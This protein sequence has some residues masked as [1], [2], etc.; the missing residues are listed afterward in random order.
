MR[1][2]IVEDN[3]AVRSAIRRALTARGHEIVEAATA[4]EGRVAVT[5][6]LDAIVLDV[7][8]PDGSGFDVCRTLRETGV[9]TPILMLTAMGESEDRIAGLESG[10]DDYLAKPFEPRELLLRIRTILRR[11]VEPAPPSSAA[12]ATGGEVLFGPF[13]FDL[14][15]NILW[16]GTVPVRLT[17][18]EATLLRA[19]ALAPG[20]TFSREDLVDRNA[21][22]GGIRTADVQITRL[23][24]KIEPDP[25]YPRFLQTVRGKGYV[26][27]LES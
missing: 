27:R 19:F 1:I 10:V 20:V 22:N 12:P 6:D 16:R 5:D 8:L 24:R 4:A 25:K 26:L 18:A 7:N 17:E 9:R 13:R 14:G 11:M 2:L 21:V 23:R 15:Q 3:E